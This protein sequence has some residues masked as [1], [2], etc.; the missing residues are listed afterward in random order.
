MLGQT[1]YQQ[2][3]V[4]TFVDDV[5]EQYHDVH[6]LVLQGEVDNLEVVVGIQHVQ[7]FNDLLVGDVA[8]TERGCLVEDAQGI[9]HAT[10]S[11]LGN[12]GQ[13]FLFNGDAFLLSHILQVVDGIAHRHAL[14][15]VNLT[16][17]QDGGQYLVLLGSCQDEDDVCGW[18]LQR[19][20]EGVEGGC[21]QHVNLVDDEYLVFTY[22]RWNAR[23]LHQRLDVLHR[24][25]GGSIKLEDVKRALFV[26][27]LTRLAL[28]TSL[29][30]GRRRLA[31][32]GFGKDSC[33][34][35]LTHTTWSAEEIGMSQLSAADGI[36][37]RSGQC[38]LTYHCVERH[39][40][41]FSC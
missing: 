14:E 21:R 17:A 16:A 31:V 10:V 2:T 5:V 19:L 27:G 24:V 33:T 36:L 32:D 1:L 20:Q 22:L 40:A 25:V 41:V 11:L 3:T 37:Q 7:V 30:I 6:G 13:R 38:L 23:L 28:S 4:E 35:C 8:L 26:K 12:N 9:A 18:L 39:R 34:G 15:V 29:T